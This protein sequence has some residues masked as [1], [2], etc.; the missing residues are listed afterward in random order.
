[1]HKFKILIIFALIFL[2]ACG[3]NIRSNS[4]MR[5]Q[6]NS[7][8]SKTIRSLIKSAK[9]VIEVEEP[10]VIIN[11]IRAIVSETSGYIDNIHDRDKKQVSLTVKI[12]EKS[13][14][15]FVA[16]ISSMGELISKS[17][18][19]KDITEEMI[20]IDAKLTNLKVL[21][22]RFRKL[23][24]KAKDVSDVLKIEN[25]LSRV[26]SEIDAIASRKKSLKNQIAL[27]RVD[28]TLN[29]KTVYGPL[30]YLGKGIYWFVKKLFIIK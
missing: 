17:L 8:Y 29:K 7:A 12:P 19:T 20:D 14:D 27:S 15:S 28:I 2:T 9:L 25:E 11:E 24:D 5:L 3:T 1:M 4:A 26:Q 16:N 21:R 18:N 10:K 23:L 6:S 30:G 22:D 13:L